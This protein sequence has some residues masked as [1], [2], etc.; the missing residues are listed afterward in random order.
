MN[1]LLW[2]ITLLAVLTACGSKPVATSAPVELTKAEFLT[3]VA[4]YETTPTEFRYL[5]DKPALIDFY[6]PW[7]GPCRTLSPILEELAAEY[8]DRIVVYK[9]NTDNEPEVAAVFGVQSLPTLL[10]IPTEGQPQMSVG[11]LPKEEL[12]KMIDQMLPA[13]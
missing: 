10:F 13:L 9:V 1:K 8:G 7:C 3:R 5:G 12:K 6:A 11:L 2:G 4:N